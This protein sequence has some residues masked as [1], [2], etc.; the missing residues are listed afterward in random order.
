M[1]DFLE[2]EGEGHPEK[3]TG[4]P[5]GVGQGGNSGPAS[6]VYMTF[7]RWL[8][9]V[10]SITASPAPYGF[11]SPAHH[12]D[13]G[14]PCRWVNGPGLRIADGLPSMAKTTNHERARLIDFRSD[15]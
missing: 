3:T 7:F 14:Q 2:V 5:K 6:S 13:S 12:N 9:V 11:C 4:P 8:V 10:L 15:R 1:I